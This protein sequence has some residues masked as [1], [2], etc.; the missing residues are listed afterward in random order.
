M[1]LVCA[2]SVTQSCPLF[3]TPWTVALQAPLPMKFF[4][5]E[6]WSGLPFPPLGNFP[7]LGIR[8]ASLA[9]SELAGK[10]FTTPPPGKTK[11]L[12]RNPLVVQW[13]GLHASTAGGLGSV[14]GQGT[15]ILH[16]TQQSSDKYQRKDQ[17]PNT[18]SMQF[19]DLT[20]LLL[21]NFYAN[22]LTHL[23]EEVKVLTVT[24]I[25][26]SIYFY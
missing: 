1:W 8:F 25:F 15:R 6:Y 21:H 17:Q 10:C 5:Q 24:F 16:A 13:L 12:E 19:T 2:S 18:K 26:F 7:S 22:W 23:C 3:V 14:R 9:S 4:M 20:K 11:R